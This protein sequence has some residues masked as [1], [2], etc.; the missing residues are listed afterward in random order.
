MS[1]A[2]ACS[3]VH[4]ARGGVQGEYE[5]DVLY[6]LDWLAT[7]ACHLFLCVLGEETLRV[8]PYESMSRDD[9]IHCT[10]LFL[11]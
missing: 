5:Q 3:K 9:S 8:C 6:G 4:A 2:A 7:G 1:G 10:W 11:A